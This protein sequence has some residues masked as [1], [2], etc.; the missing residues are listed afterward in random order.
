MSTKA[1]LVGINAYAD[2]PLKGC[3]N[4]VT[5]MKQLLEQK[6]ATKGADVRVIT[7]R[8]A[9]RAAIL[10]G[11]RWLAE[12]T[13][14]GGTRLF[15]YSGHG[16]R[17]GDRNKDEIDGFDECLVPQDQWTSGLL[18][19][20]QLAKEYKRFGAKSHVVLLMDSC[21]SGTVQRAP[22]EDI[23]F[24][25]LKPSAGQRRVAK[26]A[27]KEYRKKLVD[28]LTRE[29]HSRGLKGKEAKDLVSK[30]VSD[31]LDDLL[32]RRFGV[33]TVEGNIVLIAGSQADGTSA[34]AKF[35]STYNGA[36]TH[37][38]LQG[39]KKGPIPYDKLLTKVAKSLQDNA[40]AQIPQLES[41]EKN[42]TA[43]FLNVG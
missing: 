19:D 36:L 29:V 22:G 4:D 14:K 15:H 41:S 6:Y 35:G 43:K 8:D 1:L 42:R 37:F 26:A 32:R 20:D 9:T 13:D 21:N 5:Q 24:R 27:A 2:S 25:F 10:A 23:R 40:F 28:D 18:T 7:D 33:Q 16:T 38:L 30:L 34:D 31:K 3:V 39:L 17:A 11:I 12:G